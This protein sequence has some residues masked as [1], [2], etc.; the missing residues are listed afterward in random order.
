V[1]INCGALPEQLIES[2]LFGHEKGSFTGADRRK[3]G[4]FEAAHGGTLF[5]D[6]IGELRLDLQAKLLRA[7]EARRVTRVG[8]NQEVDVDVRIVAASNRDLTAEAKAGRFRDDLFFR[9]SAFVVEIPPLRE[10][11]NEIGLLAELFARQL[12]VA[13]NRPTPR[14]HEK[15]LAILERYDW[16]GNVRELRN[17]IE[18][19]LV[20]VDGDTIRVE[21]L[22][23][24][25]R[26]EPR[27]AVTGA[28]RSHLEQIERRAIEDALAAEEGNQTRAARR[29]GISR[30][31]LI[32]R[33]EKYKLTR[34]DR[35]M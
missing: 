27:P 15:A 23:D 21:H 28:I 2:E 7:L 1:R 18:R 29:L 12:S 11:P 19:A 34:R 6:E 32:Y 35:G 3:L 13:A 20:L 25:L 4:K 8:G 24:M 14:L 33:L 5:L 31:T 30:R 26:D 22:P 16:P 9:L 10:R 17:V